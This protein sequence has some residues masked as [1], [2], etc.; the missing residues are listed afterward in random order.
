MYLAS[1]TELALGSRLKSLSDQFYAAA[2]EVYVACGA[3]IESRWFPVM[4]FLWEQGP[5]SVT[6]VAGAIGQTHSA[7]SQLADKLVRAGMVRRRADP[8]D[9][10][11]CVLTLTSKGS[12]SLT[13]LGLV[14]A[15]IR[16]GVQDSLG[17]ESGRLLKALQACERALDKRP[18]VPQILARHA[19][20]MQSQVRIVP[21]EPSLR[22]HFY[23]L[24]AAWLTKHFVIE[25][26]DEQVLRDPENRV[27]KP[28]GAIFFA[29]LGDAVIGTCALLREK[30]GVYE[31]SKMGVDASFRG[32]GAGRRLLD[33]AIA[34]FQRRRGRTLFLESNSSLKTA[35]HMYERAGFV[36]QP[37]IREGSHYARAD[38][39]MVYAPNA[40]PE[41]A[42]A[43][44]RATRQR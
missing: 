16:Q 39:Y 20:L 42:A 5:A 6:E 22:E 14:W 25:P 36:L 43:G 33:A 12:Q 4:R 2:D 35:L 8:A 30:P 18:I 34:E 11:R 28:G 15:A 31:L 37:T 26:I 40:A 24:N 29:L 38:V 3:G 27:L 21:F 1:L 17:A 19:A 9:G 44:R 7:V 13:A 41:L 10:R 32:L 23:A